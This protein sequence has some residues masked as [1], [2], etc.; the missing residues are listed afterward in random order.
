MAFDFRL[1]EYMR[2]TDFKVF[3]GLFK[4]LSG[5]I[6]FDIDEITD[7]K[8]VLSCPEH[9]LELL[10]NSIGCPYFTETSPKINREIIRIL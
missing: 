10:A 9:M 8:D 5:A 2:S 4:I 7:L 6:K 1:P 3:E